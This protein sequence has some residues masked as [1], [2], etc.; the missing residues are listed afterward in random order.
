MHV[1]TGFKE[2]VNNGSHG[3]LCEYV[4][5]YVSLED[6]DS[7]MYLSGGCVLGWI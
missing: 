1:W 2:C 6:M 7:C 4:E 5:V 3:W